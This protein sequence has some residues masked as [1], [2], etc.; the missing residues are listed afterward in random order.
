MLGLMQDGPLLCQWIIERAAKY[1]GTQEVI[2]RSNEGPF[3][4]TNYAEI[5]VRALK[6]SQ[7]LAGPWRLNQG[8]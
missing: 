7:R 8:C 5:H 6:V 1:H 4:R 3:H 2:T